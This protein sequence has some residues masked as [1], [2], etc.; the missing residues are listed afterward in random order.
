MYVIERTYIT[1][2]AANGEI[3]TYLDD[4]GK[5]TVTVSIHGQKSLYPKMFPLEATARAYAKWVSENWRDH[6]RAVN[7]IKTTPLTCK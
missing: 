4:Y 7:Y 5:Y 1:N 6:V 3:V 2:S